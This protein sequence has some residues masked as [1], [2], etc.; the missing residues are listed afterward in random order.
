MLAQVL[1]GADI[2]EDTLNYDPLD[3]LSV[4]FRASLE[5]SPVDEGVADMV[6]V[7]LVRD[8]RNRK[9]FSFL[10]PLVRWMSYPHWHTSPLIQLNHS[11]SKMGKRRGRN[12]SAKKDAEPNTSPNHVSASMRPYQGYHGDLTCL[13][14]PSKVTTSML[15]EH[16]QFQ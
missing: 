6:G 8:Q 13:V 12:S 9:I 3:K 11:R 7:D 16:A 14:S 5:N 1:A 4:N 15:V 2:G 10:S